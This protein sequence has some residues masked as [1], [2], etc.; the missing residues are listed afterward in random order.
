MADPKSD[1]PAGNGSALRD[2]RISRVED[3]IAK[4]EERIR[5]IEDFVTR[6]GAG[7]VPL[8]TIWLIAG[9]AATVAGGIVTAV[10]KFK[11]LQ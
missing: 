7:G 1:R 10:L 6:E 11:G 4:H 8:K 5:I 3:A 9:V 2:Y